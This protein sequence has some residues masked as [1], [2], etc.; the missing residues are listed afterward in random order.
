MPK[1][2][3]SIQEL[4]RHCAD[5]RIKMGHCNVQNG[6]KDPYMHMAVVYRTLGKS[7][8]CEK[9]GHGGQ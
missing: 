6:R 9:V 5:E 4:A 8:W 7:G 3:N 1:L 2:F